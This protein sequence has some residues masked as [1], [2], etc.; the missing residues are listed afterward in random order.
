M[1]PKTTMNLNFFSSACFLIAAICFA[2]DKNYSLTFLYF[3]L[4]AC[5]L[6]IGL[7]L[8]KK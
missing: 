8:K 5:F 2:A 6:S 7:S 4:S 3:A 1:K